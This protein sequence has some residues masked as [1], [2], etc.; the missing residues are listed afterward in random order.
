MYRSLLHT[1]VLSQNGDFGT[2]RVDCSLCSLTQIKTQK[3]PKKT[4]KLSHQ[5]KDWRQKV[6]SILED[7]EGFPSVSD[8]NMY[9]LTS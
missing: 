6:T 2:S 8:N 4:T 7:L 9:K 3:K 5:E 1:E